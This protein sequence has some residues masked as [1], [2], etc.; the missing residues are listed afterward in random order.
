MLNQQWLSTFI[1]LVEEGHFTRTAEKLFMTQPGVSQ[2]IKK[3][4]QQVGCPLIIRVGKRFELTDAGLAIFEYAQLMKQQQQE[5]LTSVINDDATIGDCKIGCSGSMASLLYP[6]LIEQQQ[7]YPQLR[8]RLEAG[9]N[10]GTI[11][12]VLSNQ[13]DIGIVTQQTDKNT[14]LSRHIGE[15]S[16]CVVIPKKIASATVEPIVDYHFLEQ[17]GLIDHPDAHFYWQQIASEYFND[18]RNKEI[19]TTGYVNQL[20]Q[21]LLPVAKG[22]GFTVLPEFAMRSFTRQQD[23]Q[24]A[25]VAPNKPLT[26]FEPLYL[27][28]KRH[29]PLAK[30]YSKIV[31]LIMRIV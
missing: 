8:M 21:I 16:L 6:H 11:A 26:L 4:E 12:G 27:I 25:E 24:I 10:K 22:L 28:H 13:L 14:L 1:V 23:I 5:L 19:K 20:N 31:E 15:Q 9:P 18:A 3:L 2:H 29:K 7:A 17:L 30:R